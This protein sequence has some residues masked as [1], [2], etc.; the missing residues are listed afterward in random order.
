MQTTDNSGSAKQTRGCSESSRGIDRY[1]NLFLALM[2]TYSS[3]HHPWRQKRR[4]QRT[5]SL[6]VANAA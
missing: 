4:S 1:T 6:S 3:L 2:P 5:P